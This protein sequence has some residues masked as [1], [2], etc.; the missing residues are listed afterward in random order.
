MAE[1]TK[2]WIASAMKR[3]MAKK[4][5]D[6]I[7]VTEICREAEIERPTFYYH[8]QDKYDLVAWIFFQDADS[9]DILSVASAAAG[10]NKMRQEMLFYRRAYEDSS[11]NALWQYMLE[12]FAER[13]TRLAKEK[14][15]VDQLD[16]QLRYSIRL[17]CYGTVGMTREWILQDNITPAEVIVKMMFASM[18]ERLRQ[19]F[20]L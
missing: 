19:I 17:Y 5:L 14:L 3:L 12:Y 20:N 4:P 11:Q 1:R 16:T 13:Y 10:M 2:L 8:F 15:G 6:K 7:R 9:T 18:P